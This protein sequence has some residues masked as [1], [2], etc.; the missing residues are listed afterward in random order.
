MEPDTTWHP[1]SDR[2]F[3]HPKVRRA[4]RDA[5]L[6]Y[7]AALGYCSMHLTDGAIPKEAVDL[8]AVEAW[9][10]KKA[11]GPLV[12]ERLWHDMG[13]HYQVNDYGSWGR[14]RAE[15]EDQRRKK[16]GAGALGNHR[17][18]HVDRGVRDPGCPHCTSDGGSPPPDRNGD[19][20]CDES[21]IANGSQTIAE[22]EVEKELSKSRLTTS[23]GKASTGADDDGQ[24]SKVQAVAAIVGDRDHREAIADGVPVPKPAGHRRACIADRAGDP[25]VAVAVAANPDLD[26]AAVAA[27]V[28][29]RHGGTAPAAPSEPTPAWAGCRRCGGSNLVETSDGLAMCDHTPVL[30]SV[31][32]AA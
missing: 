12:R 18:W 19:R 2:F 3:S 4:G 14:T 32:G 21:A 13:D 1:V 7:Q 23:T 24:A 30:R 26:P 9:T 17:R 16:S 29:P 28:P 31:D 27:L 8:L 5:A 6:L 11:A 15:V 22:V 20:K 25:A 10:T